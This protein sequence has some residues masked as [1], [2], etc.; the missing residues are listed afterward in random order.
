[1]VTVLSPADEPALRAFLAKD[2]V[3]NLF[4]VGVL[5]EHGV[6]GRADGPS[7]AFW[8]EKSEAGELAGVAFVGGEGRLVVPSA[9]EKPAASALGSA[10]RGRLQIR[11]AVGE[12]EALDALWGAYGAE[13]PRLFRAQRL[14]RITPDDMGPFVAP[15]LRQ[16]RPEE[17]E[18]VVAASAE[19]HQEDLGVDPRRV[20]PDGFRRRCAER[21]A[22]G[23]TF[24]L[25][26]GGTLAFKADV[27]THCKLGAQIE[28][29]WTS[30]PFRRKG[31]ATLALGQLCRTLLSALPRVTLH[32]NEANAPAVGLYKKVGF[33]AARPFRLV[34]V[35]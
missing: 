23:R 5:D 6:S 22:A 15:Q 14:Y 13:R 8:A 18:A 33:E 35:D 21:I 9:P 11:S 12:R 10:L 29:V 20:D 26:E 31:L 19:M 17:L 24:V 4:L 1:M 30:P 2:P 3:Q 27:G 25:F 28:G 32:V 34:A 16:A 7:I